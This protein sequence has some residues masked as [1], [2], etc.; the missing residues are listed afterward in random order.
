VWAL[1][2]VAGRAR[3]FLGFQRY[4]RT[5]CW[6]ISGFFLLPRSPRHLRE[7]EARATRNEATDCCLFEGIREIQQQQQR[8]VMRVADRLVQIQDANALPSSNTRYRERLEF[9]DSVP[10]KLGDSLDKYCI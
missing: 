8:K 3:C 9:G 10:A 1:A 5:L 4:L 7:C 2:A 6:I